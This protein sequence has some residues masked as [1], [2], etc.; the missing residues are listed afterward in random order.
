VSAVRR[1]TGLRGC[2]VCTPFTVAVTGIGE[3]R[4]NILLYTVTL[5]LA[6][7]SMSLLVTKLHVRL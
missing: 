2:V 7:V 4:C 6:F 1:E 5:S 3:T